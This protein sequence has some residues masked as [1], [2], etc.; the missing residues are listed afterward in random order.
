M[1]FFWFRGNLYLLYL[2][3]NKLIKR[4]Y[5]YIHFMRRN[6]KPIGYNN[7]GLKIVPNKLIAIDKIPNTVNEF[8]KEKKLYFTFQFFTSRYKNFKVKCKNYLK[9]KKKGN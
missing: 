9:E 7:Y 1:L 8:K 4:E 2:D 3:N 6:M 5:A